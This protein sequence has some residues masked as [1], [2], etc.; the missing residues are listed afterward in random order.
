MIPEV[1][2]ALKKKRHKFPGLSGLKAEMIPA[3]GDIGIK[4]RQIATTK[5][6]VPKRTKNQV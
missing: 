1:T 3:T 2:A 5:G 4:I 6:G